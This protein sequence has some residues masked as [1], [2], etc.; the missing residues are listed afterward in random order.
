MPQETEGV[1]WISVRTDAKTKELLQEAA[2]K[3]HRPLSNWILVQ[4]I[5]AAKT[6]ARAMRSEGVL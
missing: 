2:D 5:M 3:D 4:A 6:V 1:S